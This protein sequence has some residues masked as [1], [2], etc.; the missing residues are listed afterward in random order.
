MEKTFRTNQIPHPDA[1]GVPR[2]R[3]TLDSGVGLPA[4]FEFLDSPFDLFHTLCVF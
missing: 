2:R 1:V 4:R 3:F